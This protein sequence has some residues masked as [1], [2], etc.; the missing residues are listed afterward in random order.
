MF[1]GLK[2]LNNLRQQA[3]K[4]KEELDKE[5]LIGSSEG[6]KI[7]ITMNGNQEI[8][9]VHVDPELL[10]PDNQSRIE[11]G[12]KDAIKQCVN[13]LQSTMAKKMQSGMF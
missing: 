5:T 9:A 7:Q 10:S 3:K 1:D 12:I 8:Q 6:G 11:Q 13:Q 2:N 4:I